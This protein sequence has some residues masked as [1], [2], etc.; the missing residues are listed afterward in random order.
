MKARY[1]PKS[2]FLDAEIGV[3]PSYVWRS[4]LAARV[5]VKA[6]A[7]RRIGNGMDTTVWKMPW[8]PDA[9]N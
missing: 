5:G 9:D 7:R 3:N 4:I 6:G 1:F 2:E 8:L